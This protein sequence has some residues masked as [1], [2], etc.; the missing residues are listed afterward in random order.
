MVVRQQQAPPTEKPGWVKANAPWLIAGAAG[1]IGTA[2][3]VREAR[4][5]REF[6]ERM[7]NTSHQREAADLRA[8][9]FNPAL[10][11]MGGSGASTPSGNPADMPRAIATALAI[12]QSQ[13]DIAL[14]RAQAEDVNAARALKWT[15]NFDLQMQGE[16]GKKYGRMASE[17]EI[18][19]LT[20]EQQRAMMPSLVAE[21]KARVQQVQSS[22]R[23]AKAL[24]VLAELEREGR[25]NVAR[26]EKE[27]GAMGPAGRYLLE[28][29]RSVK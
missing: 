14:T 4:K 5:A 10:T 12:R 19:N 9:G 11:A 17:A 22:A 23:Q 1:L 29:L 6:E 13:A 7:S 20:L 3:S 16:L 28:I 8:A 25:V 21:A 26:F 18:A 15:Q 27:I 24:A 2:L